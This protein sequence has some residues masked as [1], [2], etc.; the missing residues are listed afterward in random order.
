MAFLRWIFWLKKNS[1]INV[2][3]VSHLIE[4]Q[5]ADVILK[6]AATCVIISKHL[7]DAAL[8]NK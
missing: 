1:F 4:N 3:A 2:H 6:S 5:A 8:Y 7:A